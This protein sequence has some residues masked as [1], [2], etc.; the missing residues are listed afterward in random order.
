M[1][2]RE[3][4][5]KS[6]LK[7]IHDKTFQNKHKAS[8]KNFSR[9]RKLSF[10]NIVSM[11]LRLVKNSL[12]IEC[13]FFGDLMDIDPATKQAFSQA[14]NKLL[15]GAFQELHEDGVKVFYTHKTNEGLWQGY[16]IIACDGSTLR[17]PNSQ[18][19]EQEF[20]RCSIKDGNGPVMARISEFTDIT[21]KL[22]LSGRISSY[23]TS[24]A[25]LA[26]EQLVE[27][28]SKMRSLNQT[29]LLFVYDRGYPSAKFINQ[30]IELGVDFVFRLPK[31]FDKATSEI[32]NTDETE[33]FIV[34]EGSPLLRIVKIPLPTGE[35]ELLLTTLTNKT[36]TLEAL[37]EVYQGR[38]TSMEEGYKKQK[39]TMQLENFS[40]KSLISIQQEYWATLVVAN[41][42]EMGC[43]E[44]EGYWIPGNLPE[45]HVNRNVLFGSMRND[46]MKVILGLISVKE[47][48]KKADKIGK[49]SMLKRRP[50]RNFSRDGVHKPKN[51]HVYRSA[52]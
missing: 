4:A 32:V 48:E 8:A 42:L 47:Y 6:A 43:T 20:G 27:V 25:K 15:P 50:G 41:L 9:N 39:V 24:E 30:H 35:T 40:G 52:C 49:R 22:V 51:H 46:T 34:R 1:S 19:L 23:K 17:L 36:D 33:G 13:N 2:I 5:I 3:N 26:E 28:V 12:Q 14:R 10:A 29:K 18:E 31:N 37:S 7:A 38:W 11:L 16:R 45:Q 44:L 21:T